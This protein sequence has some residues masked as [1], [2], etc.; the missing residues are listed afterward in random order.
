M[1]PLFIVG[2]ARSG[3]NLL[4]RMLARHPQVTVAL[5]P[6]MPMFRSLRNAIVQTSAPEDIRKRFNPESPFKDFYFDPDGPTM[7][8]MLLQGDANLPLASGELSR[9]RVAVCERAALESPGLAGRLAAIDGATYADLIGSALA[10]IAAMKPGTTWAGCKEVWVFDFIPL[11][12]RAFPEAR[13]YAIE[14]DP[15]AIVASLLAMA[16]RD[17]SQAAHP[18]SYM[19]HWRKSVVLSRRFEADPALRGRFRTVWYEALVADP[20]AEARRMCAELG[21]EYDSGM[22]ALSADGW[23]GNSSFGAGRNVYAS[24]AERWREALPADVREACDCLCG[25][26]MALTPYRPDF[27]GPPGPRVEDYLRRVES[28]PASWRSTSSTWEVDVRGEKKR[29]ELLANPQGAES[30]VIRRHFLFSETSKA[31]CRAS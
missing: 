5:D 28:L 27:V 25:P 12:A 7:L 24:S 31:I 4:A 2:L 11:L 21:L 19:R 14:R 9:L 23:A 20:E 13:F 17:P 18:P 29:Y 8:D 15:R 10:I 30:S 16:E 22:L 3:T 6:L 1:K 26:E